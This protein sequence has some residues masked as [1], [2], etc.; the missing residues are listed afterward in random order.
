[1]RCPDVRNKGLAVEGPAGLETVVL[2]ARSTPLPASLNL[3]E[4]AARLPPSPFHD[5]REVARLD[6]APGRSKVRET[7]GR[8][9]GVVAGETREID[10]PPT[11]QWV[12]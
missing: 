3:A 12:T 1:V 9:R 7:L 6:L 5:P 10:A 4:L 8:N 11:A 2:L